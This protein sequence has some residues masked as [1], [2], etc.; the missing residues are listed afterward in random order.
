MQFY[1]RTRTHVGQLTKVH[2][3]K[4]HNTISWIKSRHFH[5]TGFAGNSI[6]MNSRL[7]TPIPI[8][9]GWVYSESSWNEHTLKYWSRIISSKRTQFVN[10]F[11][12]SS[13]IIPSTTS[14]CNYIL[15][16]ILHWVVY[17][18][19]VPSLLKIILRPCQHNNSCIDSQVTAWRMYLVSQRPVFTGHPSNLPRQKIR[20]S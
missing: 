8:P 20:H 13:K 19:F 7:S 14:N 1:V 11:N 18:H 9:D 12:Q 2:V 6:C 5:M 10:C 16:T 4:C 15:S 3:T 17:L